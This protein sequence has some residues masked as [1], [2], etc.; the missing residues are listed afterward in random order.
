MQ[1]ENGLKAEKN[2]EILAGTR[3][4]SGFFPVLSADSAAARNGHQPE[5]LSGGGSG[6]GQS[7]PLRGLIPRFPICREAMTGWET[8]PTGRSRCREILT[9]GAGGTMTSGDVSIGDRDPGT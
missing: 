5:R 1:A 3:P 6:G 2:R 9:R 4:F 7:P 8:C